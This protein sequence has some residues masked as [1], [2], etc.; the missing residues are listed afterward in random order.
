M[1]SPSD[2]WAPRAVGFAAALGIIAGVTLF[3]SYLVR[4]NSTTVALT[5]LMGVLGI[6]TKWGLAEAVTAS[7]AAMLGFNFFFLPPV[8][9]LTIE[10][11]QNWVALAA[12]LVTAVVAS[13]LSASARKRAKEAVQRQAEMERLYTLS[14]AMM[15]ADVRPDAAQ[16][17]AQLITEIFGAP[18]VAL[19]DRRAD[20]VHRA[21]AVD[22]DVAAG[23]LRDVAIQ[24]THVVDS[25]AAAFILPIRLG[26]QPLGSLALSGITVS[27]TAL[28]SVAN[29]VAI[30]LERAHNLEAASRAEAARQSEELKSML[31][32]AV[33]HDFK[34]PLTSIKASATAVLSDAGLNPSQRELLTVIDEETD[35]L[36][37][38]IT[39]AIQ[40][41]RVEAG[42]V[43]L[44]RASNQIARLIAQ[45]LSRLR[46]AL[47]G[48]PLEMQIPADLPTVVVDPDLISIALAHLLDNAVKYSP[49]GTAI[50]V[51]ARQDG[52]TVMVS[53][54]DHGPGIAPGEQSRVFERFHRGSSG[55]QVPGTGMGLSIAGEIVKVHGGRLWV[56]NL[57][58][59]GACFS[60]S[61]PL[62]A[63][64]G[65][66]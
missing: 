8:G 34:T 66:V 26:G 18:G 24:D 23:K 15:L 45:A 7:I 14:R 36:N 56:E 41:A 10:D 38:M 21:G 48:R 1:S 39:E 27:D 31:L 52:D 50:T 19:Y 63:P 4:V 9:T 3:Y 37:A 20:K 32:D 44:N 59:G 11:P 55:G 58:E 6:A 51:A 25:A 29:L 13:Q 16:K 47:E 49:P 57:R 30:A 62:E 40:V 2:R 5:L 60:F 46:P 64:V 53:V 28:Q 17:V 35:R 42:S 12:F 54:S 22:M 33:A 61:V 43:Q 65:T